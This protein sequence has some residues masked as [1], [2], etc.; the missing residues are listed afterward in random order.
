MGERARGGPFTVDKVRLSDLEAGL[1]RSS[2]SLGARHPSFQDDGEADRLEAALKM[3][4]VGTLLSCARGAWDVSDAW[5]Q[6]L[7]GYGFTR[8]EEFLKGVWEGKP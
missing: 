6:R 1:L 7:P 3:V 8:V 5:N 2:W 4:M